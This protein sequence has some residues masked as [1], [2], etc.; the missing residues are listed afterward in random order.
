[1][2]V[3]PVGV[4]ALVGADAALARVDLCNATAVSSSGIGPLP[5]LRRYCRRA[6]GACEGTAA[7]LREHLEAVQ[8]LES[9]PV[10]VHREKLP[11]SGLP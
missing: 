6:L 11:P 1:M 3:G 4:A 5:V 7:A 8:P 10:I 2:Q 9:L